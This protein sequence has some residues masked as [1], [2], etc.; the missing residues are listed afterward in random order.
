VKHS[1]SSSNRL[2]QLGLFEKSLKNRAVID[3]WLAIHCEQN[4]EG[5]DRLGIIVGKRLIAKASDRNRIKRYIREAFR[6]GYFSKDISFDI[7]VRLRKPVTFD[8]TLEFRQTLTCLLMKVRMAV[9]DTPDS[10][11][12]KKLSV[13]N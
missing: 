2:H 13:S 4:F 6:M 3:K 11:V 5:R 1:F 10:N 7:V 9:H 8:E 12:H